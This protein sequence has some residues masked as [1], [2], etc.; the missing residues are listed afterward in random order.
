MADAIRQV[1]TAH[2]GIQSGL[3]NFVS[4]LIRN[5]SPVS[6]RFYVRGQILVPTSPGSNELR[7]IV[8]KDSFKSKEG[9]LGR[10]IPPGGE[11]YYDLKYLLPPGTP[12]GPLYMNVIV[13]NAD[14]GAVVERKNG[15]LLGNVTGN[16]QTAKLVLN[17][18]VNNPPPKHIISLIK[19]EVD[20]FTE[21]M[22]SQGYVM[23]SGYFDAVTKTATIIY[24][25][26]SVPSYG[27]EPSEVSGLAQITWDMYKKSVDAGT[28]IFAPTI[29]IT[30]DGRVTSYRANPDDV[31]AIIRQENP[32]ISD[33]AVNAIIASLYSGGGGAGGGG[34]MAIAA[35]FAIA[36]ALM[37][38]QK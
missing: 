3:L 6:S 36:A 14:N 21:K 32:G 33:D 19:A 24:Y 31:A 28:R 16:A 1:D 27:A 13:D 12:I 38:T 10:S 20:R 23:N 18:D 26:E 35:A 5:T 17:F 8:G 2:G 25:K 37:L 34:G 29:Y 30:K 9:Q 22:K 11:E 4:I 15:V 7:V